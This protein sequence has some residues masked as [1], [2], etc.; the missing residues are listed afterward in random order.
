MGRGALPEGKVIVAPEAVAVPS[1]ETVKNSNAELRATVLPGREALTADPSALSSITAYSNL[2]IQDQT[3]VLHVFESLR[4]ANTPLNSAKNQIEQLL[5]IRNAQGGLVADERFGGVTTLEILDRRATTAKMDPRLASLELT[6][7]SVVK[8]TIQ[9]MLDASRACQD[10]TIATCTGC[11][12]EYS[13]LKARTL[14]DNMA[15]Y[16]ASITDLSINGEF[17]TNSATFKLPVLMCATKATGVSNL[18]QSSLM[19]FMSDFGYD[20]TT[21]TM[22]SKNGSHTGA[23]CSKVECAFEAYFDTAFTRFDRSNPGFVNALNQS[24]EMGTIN[25]G[26]ISGLSKSDKHALHFVNFINPETSPSLAEQ[27][28]VNDGKNYFFRNPWGNL[29]R[30]DGQGGAVLVDA[31]EGIYMLPKDETLSRMTYVLV[32][33]GEMGVTP[34]ATDENEAPVLFHTLAVTPPI[35]KDEEPLNTKKRAND[36]AFEKPEEDGAL[37]YERAVKRALNPETP[38]NTDILRHVA[39]APAEVKP[40][41][42]KN[43]FS[44]VS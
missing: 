21:D 43:D 3:R 10:S 6:P 41:R 20:P 1:P 37:K 7:D 44:V 19:N 32:Q 17:K 12:V 35:K 30:R 2:S 14:N 34:G 27:G 40:R 42:T 22:Y 36:I 33:G 9:A 8:Q 5:T 11:G 18:L 13:A 15:R 38:Q 16:A 25:G 31:K 4:A 23:Y 26:A 39:D 28:Y 29:D 24:I